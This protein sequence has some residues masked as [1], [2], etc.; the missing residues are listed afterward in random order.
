MQHV[1]GTRHILCSAL[2]MVVWFTAPSAV[3]SQLYLWE[4]EGC[5]YYNQNYYGGDGNGGCGH[6]IVGSLRMP[7]AYVR[8]TEFDI[9]SVGVDD[10]APWFYFYMPVWVPFHPEIRDYVTG[11]GNILLPVTSGPAS[12]DWCMS[13][14]CNGLG[15]WTFGDNFRLSLDEAYFVVGSQRF[16][17][18]P[19]YV[20]EPGTL[21]MLGLG[22]AGL[23]FARRRALPTLQSR[24][25]H[26]SAA[27]C[28]AV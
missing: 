28:E 18:V 3:A 13:E 15:F 22:L 2:L 11:I 12:I 4:G 10:E 24:A 1:C 19:T 9:D 27:V 6:R 16:T 8:G 21:A 14:G 5:F 7:D 25:G 23:G 20:P 17:W 26:T